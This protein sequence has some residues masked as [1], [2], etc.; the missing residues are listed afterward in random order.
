M[1]I[2]G[3][4]ILSVIIFSPVIGIF[5]ISMFRDEGEGTPSK[6]VSLI[7]SIVTFL[8][9]LSLWFNFDENTENFQMVEQYTWIS[10][11][12]IDYFIGLDGLNFFFF[13]LINRN[14]TQLTTAR[15][16][17]ASI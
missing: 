16:G 1:D 10:K 5:F 12:N 17:P 7:S 14:F 2:L 13:L 3:L 9:S 6:V 15:A 8:L 11:F 4:P